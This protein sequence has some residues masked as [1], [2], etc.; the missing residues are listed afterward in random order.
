[1]IGM[2]GIAVGPDTKI[3][4]WLF[5]FFRGFVIK[6]PTVVYAVFWLYTQWSGFMS[7]SSD[8]HAGG[9]AFACHIS[10]FFGGMLLYPFVKNQNRRLVDHGFGEKRIHDVCED[11]RTDAEVQLAAA[12]VPFFRNARTVAANYWISTKSHR[13][14]TAARRSVAFAL[15]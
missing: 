10:S 1:M 11:A 7:S 12:R 2:Y 9:V 15:T 5:F 6:V 14:C 4:T 8:R 13:I 3:K